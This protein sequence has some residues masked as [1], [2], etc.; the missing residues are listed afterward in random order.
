MKGAVT[1]KYSRVLFLLAKT[2]K[3]A[4]LYDTSLQYTVGEGFIFLLR[5]KYA[6]Q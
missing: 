2:L 1:A 5:I 4:G 6:V 3:I